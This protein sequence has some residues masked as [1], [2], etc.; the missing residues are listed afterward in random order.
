M[1]KRIVIGVIAA[2]VIGVAAY[3]LSKLSQPRNGSVEWHKA[4]YMKCFRRMHGNTVWERTERLAK[5]FVGI[6]PVTNTQ[7]KG[8]L[9]AETEARYHLSALVRLGYLAE[10]RYVITNRSLNDVLGRTYR[11]R[12]V[13][14]RKYM[15]LYLTERVQ[16]ADQLSVVA[17]PEVASRYDEMIRK[18]EVPENGE[19]K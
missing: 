7:T 13:L 12:R 9:R 3:V 8:Q 4:K 16:G 17:L 18:A 6:A 19:P 5:R 14:G 11:E 10:R 1:R 2:V 15:P